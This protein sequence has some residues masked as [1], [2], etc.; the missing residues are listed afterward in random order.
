M[1]KVFVIIVLVSLYNCTEECLA[2][3]RK[4]PCSCFLCAAHSVNFFYIEAKI[5]VLNTFNPVFS[6]DSKMRAAIF[7]PSAYHKTLQ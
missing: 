3:K 7:V 2:A 5:F 4:Q 1:N 6:E